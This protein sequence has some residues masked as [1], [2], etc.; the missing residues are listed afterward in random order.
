VSKFW[1]D[2]NPAGGRPRGRWVSDLSLL[3]HP[4]GV[5][6]DVVLIPGESGE[7][8]AFRRFPITEHKVGYD[9]DPLRHSAT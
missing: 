6:H 9:N 5:P 7:E 8:R 3:T 4:I 2:Y 1:F